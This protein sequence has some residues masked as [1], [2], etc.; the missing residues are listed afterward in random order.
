MTRRHPTRLLAFLLIV[1]GC[2]TTGCVAQKTF[3]WD[4]SRNTNYRQHFRDWTRTDQIYDG[5]V[6]RATSMATCFSPSFAG[7][8][9]TERSKRA[10]DDSQSAALKRTEA[11]AIAKEVLTFFVALHTQNHYWNDLDR[12]A[13]TFQVK[14]YADANPAVTPTKVQ[15]LNQN[16]M[17]D[18]ST[19]FPTV[20]PLD[21]GYFISFDPID[22]AREIR[23]LI[24]GNPGAME[25]VW[26]LS[27]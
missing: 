12:A 8:L 10:R 2:L 19:L 3:S 23:L 7:E 22:D 6:A 15:R 14:L 20:G 11:E 5:I 25:M 18:W 4:V 24:S 1:T 9:Q 27:H 21:T 17:A 16:Q 26:K 13:S